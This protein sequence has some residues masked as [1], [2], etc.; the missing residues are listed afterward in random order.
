MDS[1]SLKLAENCVITRVQTGNNMQASDL[2]DYGLVASD[3][4]K[5]TYSPYTSDGS[6][7]KAIKVYK[8]DYNKVVIN[9]DF[10]DK[11]QPGLR[12]SCF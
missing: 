11:D 3:K 10:E 2:T 12:E 9:E 5:I 4:I 1:V 8:D 7:I 6:S